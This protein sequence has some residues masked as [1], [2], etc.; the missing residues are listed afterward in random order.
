MYIYIY[1][2]F[3]WKSSDKFKYNYIHTYINPKEYMYV[4]ANPT[5]NQKEVRYGK[6]L[7]VNQLSHL[8]ESE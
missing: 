5:D 3:E 1:A 2:Y 7:T 8:L 4:C 6:Q